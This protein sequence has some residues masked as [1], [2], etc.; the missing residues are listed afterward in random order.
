MKLNCPVCTH[1]ISAENIALD[2]GWAKCLRCDE[3]FELCQILPGYSRPLAA[4][5]RERPF[6]AW[7]V[8]ERRERQL[9]IH[10]PPEGMRAAT[11]GML[12]FATFWLGFIA[13]WTVGAL[14]VF[15]NNGAVM[16][17]NGW[18][19]AFSIPFWGV[20]F[21][22]LVGVVWSARGTRTVYIDAA[23]M[24]S[25]LRCLF[26][27]RRK[28][29]DRN[30]VQHARKGAH[31]VKSGGSDSPPHSFPVEIVFV[32]GSFFLPCGTE[33]EQDWLVAEINEFLQ[34]VPY[35]PRLAEG[36]SAGLGSED[37]LK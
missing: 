29:R 22:M 34:T 12:G 15:F 2:A 4:S 8:L 23:H 36:S 10:F 9:F 6:D 32:K 14:G 25:E 3:V 19:A 13:F 17:Q 28:V 5:P 18:F 30:Q 31:R 26:W 1:V 20:G 35:D 21:A 27:R 11:W 37:R 33:D 16:P 24:I 7:A